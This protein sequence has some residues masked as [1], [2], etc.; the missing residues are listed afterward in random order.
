[1]KTFI[2]QQPWLGVG[3]VVF[4]LAGLGASAI[5][6]Q[7]AQYSKMLVVRVTDELT[8]ELVKD[9]TVRVAQAGRAER[10]TRTLHGEQ[11]RI[12]I[13]DAPYTMTVEAKGYQP[14]NGTITP[15][16]SLAKEYPLLVVLRPNVVSGA[17]KDGETNKPILYAAVSASDAVTY[18]DDLGRFTLA[19]VA[20]S[21]TVHIVASGYYVKEV[22]WRGER[23]LSLTMTPRTVVVAVQSATDSKP[24]R[25][26]VFVS[27]VKY[28]TDAQGRISLREPLPNTRISASH[29]D[30]ASAEVTY[31]GQA[32]VELVLKPVAFRA[33][34]KNAQTGKPIA[35]ATVYVNGIATLTTSDEGKFGLPD[36]A[37]GTKLQIKA[38]GYR[39]YETTVGTAPIAEL[40][41]QP[42]VAR[43][44]YVPFGLLG[45][46]KEVLKLIDLVDQTELNTLVVDV[47]GDRG[48]L[49]FKP[50]SPLLKE[51]ATPEVQMDLRALLQRAR[52]KN[53]Y[54]IAR[55]VT[56]K[57]DPL[58]EKRPDLAVKTKSGKA[59][60]DGENL[61]WANPYS[62]EVWAYNSA[63]AKEA[64]AL[65]FDEIQFD[66]IR[67]PS[68]G[69]VNAMYF[70][71]PHNAETRAAALRG[72]LDE[73][74]RALKPH[75]VFVSADVFGMTVW[76]HDDMGIGQRLEE[77]AKQV[78]Y[79]QPMI[80]PSTF[81][82][83]NLG[84]ANPALYPYEVIYRSS[85]KAMERV[86]TPIR[87][88][89]QAYSSGNVPYG[90]VEFL[91]QKR[92]ANEAG[93]AGWTFW[94]SRGV[95]PTSLFGGQ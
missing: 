77:L 37:P 20:L 55:I 1:M 21:E 47:K 14:T 88:W 36:A 74:N 13:A 52:A 31:T 78:D 41:L 45:L 24:L 91:K 17:V 62:R 84:Y 75:A 44:I 87:P 63:I 35:N 25:A 66:Y 42:F 90:V 86:P 2:T 5:W 18:T 15:A 67:F 95:Y 26:S 12:G 10:E 46:E 29:P 89:L 65:G 51:L 48:K 54:V 22:I 59:W 93:T 8:Q 85:K 73:V 57:D 6:W 81:S 64:A 70:A 83:G 30:F 27:G 32:V 23:E 94:N 38:I 92:A 72:F 82:A 49:A 9:A 7:E 76:T 3:I 69:D 39:V 19:R 34:V 53:I 79:L 56:F 71:P 50:E 16:A 60:K 43:G 40:A 61:A 68:D 4:V 28:Q 11:Y 80:Y 58:A 33:T